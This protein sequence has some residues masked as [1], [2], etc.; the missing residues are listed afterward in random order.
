MVTSCSAEGWKQYGARFVESFFKHWPQDVH[1][2]LV[3]ED[4]LANECAKHAAA[5]NLTFIDMRKAIGI[6][7]ERFGADPVTTGRKQLPG[8]RGW[9]PAK[10]ARSYNFR[11]DAARF[12]LKT[13]AIYL[14]ACEA[15]TGRLFWVDADVYTFAPVKQ[16]LLG[17]LLPDV[18]A[19]SCLDRGVTYHS[20]CGFVGY[21]LGHPD[22]LPFIKA[23]SALYESGDVMRLAE[24]HDSWVFD[25]LRRER[26]VSTYCIPHTSKKHPFVNSLLGTCLDHPKGDR[27]KL[28]KTPAG[29]VAAQYRQHDYWRAA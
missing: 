14:A 13:F 21:N 18:F 11:Y 27:K 26:R 25:W 16:T 1:L 19:L 10:L 5:P 6:F 4:D 2:F 8:Q 9:S 15:C 28:G 12:G 20:E 7:V 17:E 29:E 24:W 23:F 22:T 3:S